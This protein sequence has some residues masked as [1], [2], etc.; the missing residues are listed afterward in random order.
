MIEIDVTHDEPGIHLAIL[1]CGR[2][3][4]ILSGITSNCI[5]MLENIL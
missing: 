1:S 5:T 4:G 2:N 3:S